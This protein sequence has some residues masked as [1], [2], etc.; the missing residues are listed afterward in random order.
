MSTLS[1]ALYQPS[2]CS[3]LQGTAR[4]ALN[5]RGYSCVLP[6]VKKAGA[7]EVLHTGQL[8][9]AWGGVSQTILRQTSRSSQP[10]GF[11]IV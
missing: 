1:A 3:S 2:R 9:L 4:Q 7:L 6:L 11:R 10:V 8:C 5:S